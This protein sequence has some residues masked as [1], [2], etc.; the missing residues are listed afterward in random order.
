MLNG[1]RYMTHDEEAGLLRRSLFLLNDLDEFVRKNEAK[2]ETGMTV[3]PIQCKKFEAWDR[4]QRKRE[5]KLM[6]FGFLGGSD[7]AGPCSTLFS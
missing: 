3:T 7:S 6:G 1:G 5:R 4:E 2:P